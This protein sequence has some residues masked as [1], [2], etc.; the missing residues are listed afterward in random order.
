MFRL[1]TETDKLVTDIR[2]FVKIEP[3]TQNNANNHNKTQRNSS[4]YN[5]VSINQI[6]KSITSR[7]PAK[8]NILTPFT[9]RDNESDLKKET[10][11]LYTEDDSNYTFVKGQLLNPQQVNFIITKLGMPINEVN[12]NDL[13]EPKKEVVV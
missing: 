3:L 5:R 10:V 7:T 8:S 2:K 13:I 9:E 1:N 4:Q 12:A 11:K 6:A